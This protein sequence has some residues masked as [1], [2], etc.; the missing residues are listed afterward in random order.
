MPGRDGHPQAR[1]R[2]HVLGPSHLGPTRQAPRPEDLRPRHTLAPEEARHHRAVALG[3]KEGR[4]SGRAGRVQP[5][6]EAPGSASRARSR[7]EATAVGSGL[8]CQARAQEARDPPTAAPSSGQGLLRHVPVGARRGGPHGHR[9]AL[10]GPP[11]ALH[12][13]VQAP[14]QGAQLQRGLGRALHGA[15]DLRV[16]LHLVQ[17]RQRPGLHQRLL[18]L[19]LPDPRLRHPPAPPPASHPTCATSR[20]HQIPKGEPVAEYRP[21]SHYERVITSH[22]RFLGPGRYVPRSEAGQRTRSSSCGSTCGGIPSSTA[23]WT[24]RTPTWSPG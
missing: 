23:S 17:G 22:P 4:T 16:L 19:R 8:A 18:R 2:P 12:R 3:P 1:L 10:P 11:D 13:D 21:I 7:G 24:R 5:R 9:R 20:H 15:G 14:A 6:A